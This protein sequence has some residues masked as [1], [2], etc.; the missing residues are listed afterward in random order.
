MSQSYGLTYA[1]LLR[2]VGLASACEGDGT[3][4]AGVETVDDQGEACLVD[5]DTAPYGT[6]VTLQADTPVTVRVA[7]DACAPCGENLQS[8]CSI[9]RS[10]STLTVTA[11][12]SWEPVDDCTHECRAW[13]A[14]CES[15]ALEAGSYTLA[16]G[17]GAEAFEVPTT[18][19][20][21]CAEGG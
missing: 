2:V 17:P 8:S 1:A 20:F 10:G 5:I 9:A 19:A 11:T 12:S 16:Y 15:E 4:P 3:T 21:V 13:F 6:G 14:E 7:F 18:G